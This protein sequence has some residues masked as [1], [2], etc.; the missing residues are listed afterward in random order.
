MLVWTP[1]RLPAGF[2]ARVGA[3]PGVRHAVAVVS[4][5]VQLTQSL[6]GRG[7]V[8]DRPPAGMAIP[9]DRTAG[10]GAVG[11]TGVMERLGA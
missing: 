10:T 4:G 7:Q 9:L 1:N 2:A 3:L 8:V 11:T 6:D 5:S